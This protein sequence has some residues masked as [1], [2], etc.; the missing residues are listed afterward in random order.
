MAGRVHYAGKGFTWDPATDA[1]YYA[2]LGRAVGSERLRLVER[3]V[4]LARCYFDAYFERFPK[5]MPWR[6]S[7][8][9]ADM[10]R[11][12][13]TD[14]LGN[15]VTGRHVIKIIEESLAAPE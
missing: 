15:L 8:L 4:E 12:R 7:H 3:Q 2:L 14:E 9:N 10:Q 1:D 5:K 11:C 13:G 6:W